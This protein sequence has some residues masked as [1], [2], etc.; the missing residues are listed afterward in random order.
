MVTSVIKAPVRKKRLL[1]F[2]DK[3]TKKRIKLVEKER[4]L[5]Q[6]YLKH[7][8]AWI[9]EHG[10]DGTS[11]DG[12][13]GPVTLLPRALMDG[14]DLPYKGPKSSKTGYIGKRYASFDVISNKFPNNWVP[15]GFNL[16]VTKSE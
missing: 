3:L 1:T 13:L 11:L 10:I 4:R 14:N 7:Q 5:T 15:N 9:N 6:R 12:L 8:L 16:K 2:T